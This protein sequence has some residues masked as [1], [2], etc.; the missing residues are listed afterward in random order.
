MEQNDN[1]QFEN[2]RLMI[3]SYNRCISR[4]FHDDRE[5]TNWRCSKH[6]THTIETRLRITTQ[7]QNENDEHTQQ[8]RIPKQ[9]QVEKKRVKLNDVNQTILMKCESR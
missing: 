1:F 7:E 6:T 8:Y 3:I 4:Q 5:D 2:K 9:Q